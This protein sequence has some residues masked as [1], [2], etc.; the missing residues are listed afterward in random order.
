MLGSLPANA[1]HCSVLVA[2]EVSSPSD[3]D[4][5]QAQSPSLFPV[6]PGYIERDAS[7]TV[8]TSK[9]PWAALLE[10]YPYV[11]AMTW[12][13][14]NTPSGRLLKTFYRLLVSDMLLYASIPVT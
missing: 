10:Y 13:L 2:S 6:N 14:G 11:Q 4:M 9:E 12:S 1:D 3:E 5:P 7:N 8:T